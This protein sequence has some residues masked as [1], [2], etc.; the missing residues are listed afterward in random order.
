M[1]KS[2]SRSFAVVVTAVGVV[3]TPV[4]GLALADQPGDT[5]ATTT[6]PLPPPVEPSAPVEVEVPPVDT[7]PVD[8]VP[9]TTLVEVPVPEV[10][11]ALP[12]PEPVQITEDVPVESPDS[13]E[14]TT[15]EVA[16]ELPVTTEKLPPAEDTTTSPVVSGAT[17]EQLGETTQA[18]EPST[19]APTGDL[20]VSSGVTTDPSV[21]ETSSDQPATSES[22]AGTSSSPESEMPEAPEVA[23]IPE[24]PQVGREELQQVFAKEPIM[25]QVTP[26]A[27]TETDKIYDQIAQLSSRRDQDDHKGRPGDGKHDKDEWDGK[28]RPWSPDWIKYDHPGHKNPV[29]CN[30]YHDRDIKIIYV[31]H[32]HQYVQV[33]PPRQTVIVNVDINVPNVYSFTAVH[34]KA[35]GV[36]VDVN[37]GTFHPWGYSPPVQHDVQVKVVVNN[38][39]YP[40]PFK[41]KKVVDCG[42]DNVRRKTRVVFDD[43]YVAW[44]HWQGA[45]KDRHFALEESAKFPGMYG[46]A[47]EIVAAPPEP[48]IQVTQPKPMASEGGMSTGMGNAIAG[49]FLAFAVLVVGL[50]WA[51]TRKKSARHF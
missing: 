20:P 1:K 45:G 46:K 2:L 17:D 43:T 12:P 14:P 13:S 24:S 4:A 35:G 49:A 29:F 8:Q 33:I 5:D 11:E 51:L 28:V 9:Q 47:A 38:H 6:I 7:P 31:Y 25:Q 18:T 37:V 15:D 23:S 32:G 30:P 40:K 42:Y 34:V 50:T 22:E 3:L 27:T 48:Y 21:G 41:V 36:I 39:Y 26:V 19:D 44:G 10:S 16:E